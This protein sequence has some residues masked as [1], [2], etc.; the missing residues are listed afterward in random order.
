MLLIKRNIQETITI[1][2]PSDEEII[3]TLIDIKGKKAIIGFDGPER[4]RIMRNDEHKKEI[5]EQR[6]TDRE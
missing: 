2:C 3:I 4:Y 1:K 5:K 6:K